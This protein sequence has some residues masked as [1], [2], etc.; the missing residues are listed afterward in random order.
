MALTVEDGSGLAGADSYLSVADADT[1]HTG[2]NNPATWSGAS[3]ATKEEA[4]RMAA[5]YLDAI[6]GGRW[7]GL[8]KGEGQALDWPRAG[9]TDYDGYYMDSSALP[10]KLKDMAAEMALRNITETSGII[11]DI[12]EPGTIGSEEVKV[13]SISEK[14]TYLGGKSQIKRYRIVDLLAR[15]LSLPLGRLERS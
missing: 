4:L 10:Q 7:L 13:G 9:A 11:P 15:G 1:Y 6:Y 3:T 2:H 8:K 5:Q 12:S 14:K